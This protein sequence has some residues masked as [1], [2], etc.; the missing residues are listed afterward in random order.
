MSRK[1]L[2]R[3]VALFLIL[4]AAL[5]IGL[6]AYLLPK[7]RQMIYHP[8]PYAETYKVALPAGA[9]EIAYTVGG[10]AQRSFY[11]PPRKAPPAGAAPPIMV[12]FNGN[13]S[14]ALDWLD[15]VKQSPR[16]DLAFFLVDYPGY[17]LC[18]GSPSRAS[19]IGAVEASWPALA[20]DLGVS[21]E[22]LDAD[23]STMGFSM[24]A[25]A[26]MEFAA[27]RPVKK[28][29]LL[30]PFT[31]LKDMAKRAAGSFVSLFL[32]DRFD[33]R[34]RLDEL[35]ARTAPPS[36]LIC[37]GDRDS[38]IPVAMGRELAARH[39]AMIRYK[40]YPGVDH[41]DLPGAARDAILAEFAGASL[42]N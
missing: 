27:R 36:V 32:L 19:I 26:A 6:V 34:A 22:K 24:G 29:V 25:A 7:Q 11:I 33:N 2:F 23:V 13:A 17:G 42:A 30:A 16:Q 28:V 1:P 35:A 18:E 38:V 9:R 41:G 31:S 40:E 20:R 15:Q 21:V 37:H 12:L 3:I 39:P 8:R 5:V 4:V 10:K 14:L